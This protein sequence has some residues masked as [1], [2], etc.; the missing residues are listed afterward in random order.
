MSYFQGFMMTL[1]SFRPHS[2][3]ASIMEQNLSIIY[4]ASYKP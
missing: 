2:S 4:V 1:L 3:I